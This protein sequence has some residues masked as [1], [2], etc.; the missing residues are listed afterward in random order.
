MSRRSLTHA[1]VALV[2]VFSASVALAQEKKKPPKVTYDDDVKPIFQQKC[3]SCHNPDKKEGDLDLTN[4]TAMM[5]GGGSG[6]VVEAG[7]SSSSYLYLLVTHDS[8]P[9]MPPKQPK[10]PDNTIETIRKWIDGGVLENKGSKA[11]LPKKKYN[12]ALAAPSNER[13][14]TPPLPPRLSLEPPVTA[15]ATTAVTAM[16]TSP[17]VPLLALAGQKQVLLYDTKTR[18]LK[19]T[20]DFPEGVP[21]ILKFSRN[22]SLL[23]AGGGRGGA[24]GKVVVWNVKTGERIMEVGNELD[25]VLCADISSD[26]G[27]I[28]LGGP[29]RVVRIYETETGKLIHE[30]RKHTDWI[31]SLEFSPDSVLLTSGDRAGNL[32]V[33]EAYTGREY[34]VLKGHGGSITGVSWR[35]DSNVVATSSEDGTIRLWE[36]ENGGQIRSWGAHGGGASWVEFSRDGRLVSCGRDRT[37]KLWQQDGKQLIAFEAFSEMATRT[38]I[39]NE[40]N[41]VIAGDW[42]G[43]IRVWNAADGKRSGELTANPPK[44]EVRIAQAT[45]LVKQRTAE[46]TP[47]A[48]AYQAAKSAADKAK[49]DLTKAQAAM[50]AA[51]KAATAATAKVAADKTALDKGTAE[52]QAVDKQVQALAG[53]APALTDAATKAEAAA[54]LLP[55]DKELVELAAKLKTIAAAR[56]TAL[57][58]G[59]K[60]AAAKTVVM[61]NA[62]KAYTAA[63]TADAAAKKTLETAKQLVAKVTPTVKPAEEAAAGAKAT[64]D[65]SAAALKTAQDSL[66]K[67]QAE[68]AF[69]KQLK[70][71]QKQRAEATAALEQAQIEAATVG[72]SLAVANKAVTDAKAAV[73][74]ANDAL[75]KAV[76][77][78]KAA[79]D[80]ANK[81]K[82]ALAAATKQQADY[83]T[84]ETQ[85]G[86]LIGALTA[87]VTSTDA[88]AKKAGGKDA[89]LN[90]ALAK[91]K[92]VLTAKQAAKTKTTADAAAK[93]KEME[94]IKAQVVAAD[95]KVAAMTTAMDGAKKIVADR[96]ATLKPL[97]ET[98]AKTKQASDA[99][100][101]KVA[102][103]QKNFDAVSGQIAAAMGVA[104][105]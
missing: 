7:D 86:D 21:H 16:S 87:A 34:L 103:A 57:D 71:L 50:A 26:Q 47:K 84:Q 46:N 63:T 72:Q 91:I 1:L 43:A 4:Y 96:T 13:P 75:A 92:S 100:A 6:E 97:E 105:L 77:A 65:A 94:T 38:T 22:G 45:E 70:D 89:D 95:K 82:A 12:L 102:A 53:V 88:A 83:K 85:L 55:G 56:T 76:A 23:L 68:L 44:I 58:T 5:Q 11:L 18:E 60:D 74:A 29:Q 104:S 15:N 25:S 31:Y 62:Q 98:A 61:Q 67:W 101:T 24:G 33:W 79:T 10:L 73:A 32:F 2:A 8:E 51:Q 54:K 69:A 30:L 37:T 28:A 36:M 42:N 39:C 17:W 93:A 3:F 64:A 52:K 40:T 90:D 80:E 14:E 9:Y 48:A 59:K 66:A 99:A 27:L 19:G 78:N 49:A 81:V 20:L 41:Q 35:N